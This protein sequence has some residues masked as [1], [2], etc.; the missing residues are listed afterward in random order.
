MTTDSSD[1]TLSPPQRRFDLDWLRIG[2]FILLIL[3]HIGMFY[4]TWD[5]H[6]KSPRQS[7]T[8]EVFMMI[9]NPWRMSLLFLISGFALRSILVRAQHTG[10]QGRT[11]LNRLGFLF[12]PLLFG[13]F[14]IVPPQAYFEV[15]EKLNLSNLSYTEF[16][17]RYATASGQWCLDGDC[18]TTP[19][20]N[21]LW[22]LAY[23]LV[24]TAIVG[25][26]WWIR[27]L[28]T[29]SQSLFRALTT[30]HGL[31]ITPLIYLAA[32]R[33]GLFPVFE[34][35][36]DLTEDWYNHALS[37]G[38]FLWGMGLA[39]APD[40]HERLVPIRRIM[41]GLWVASYAGFMA[42]VIAYSD[43]P[44][45]PDALKQAMRG[46]YALMQMSAL[47]TLLGY[48]ARYLRQVDGPLLKTLNTAIFPAYVVHQS[49][50]VVAAYYLAKL[51]L[52]IATEVSLLCLVTAIGCAIAWLIARWVPGAGRVLGLRR[53][54]Q[55]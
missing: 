21:H 4:V 39:S 45:P 26:L 36:H 24:Y 49:V 12:W 51:K 31:W 35:R 20:W 22:F 54:Q 40:V 23:L 6:V 48:A 1:F 37:L 16:Y 34:I 8:L 10:A 38:V 29:L 27:P 15:V 44:P 28:R 2:A 14:V 42:Y 30:G 47:Y 43:G 13:M 25:L 19:T 7:E 46:V 52:P 41:A 17:T 9:T 3:Y 32:I 11:L 50:T 18:L 33:V 5:W 55:P 53:S